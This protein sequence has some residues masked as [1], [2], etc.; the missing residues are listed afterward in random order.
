[1]PLDLQN[2]GRWV[3][4]LYHLVSPRLARSCPLTSRPTVSYHS[5]KVAT[6]NAT[7]L[8]PQL[9]ISQLSCVSDVSETRELFTSIAI[10]EEAHLV[11]KCIDRVA[12]ALHRMG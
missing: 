1:M 10:L 2:V 8:R 5:P 4:W 11:A 9:T 7:G 3:V 6:M 12:G